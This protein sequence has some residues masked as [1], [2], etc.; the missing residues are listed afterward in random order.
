[1]EK[2]AE[3]LEKLNDLLTK[4]IITQDEFLLEKEKI[5]NQTSSIAIFK[6]S[7][8]NER[9]YCMLM[10]ISMLFGLIHILLGILIP[11]ML[12][13]FNKDNS[14]S[15]NSHGK[16]IFNWML[17]AI[18]YLLS[19]ILIAASFGISFH[20]S[21]KSIS[22]LALLTPILPLSII[23]LILTLIFVIIGSVKANNNISWHYPL[24]IKFFKL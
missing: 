13:L 4:G 18:A 20:I 15:I 16:N 17:S 24:S 14:S 1:M 19:I 7:E 8:L 5:L 2:K 11:L 10:Y 6:L 9:A 21:M 22:L 12:W 3:Q 23:I